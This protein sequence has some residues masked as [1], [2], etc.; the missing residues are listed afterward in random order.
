MSV[1]WFGRPKLSEVP[2]PLTDAQQ[3]RRQQRRFIKD[4]VS[5]P[6]ALRWFTSKQKTRLLR[7]WR[8]ATSRK[9]AEHARCLRIA[10]AL[11]WLFG[12]EGYAFPTDAFLSRELGMPINKVQA[13]LLALERKQSIIRMSVFVDGKAER[14]IWPSG[15]DIHPMV[16]NTDTP[17]HAADLYPT[18]GRQNL[19]EGK[20]QRKAILSNTVLQARRAAEI[21]HR[22]QSRGFEEPDGAA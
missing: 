12:K 9:F 20:R 10:W 13:G 2:S 4:S 19:Q 1:N 18:V 14:R 6:N 7:Q 22:R 21:N 8:S 5:P 16:G 17:H 15:A 3:V 11:E